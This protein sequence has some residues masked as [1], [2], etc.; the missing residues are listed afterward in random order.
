MHYT[1]PHS[2]LGV[3]G[4]HAPVL[5]I[6]P[7]SPFVVFYGEPSESQDAELKGKL[8]LNNPESISV[9]SVRV[10]LTATRKVSYALVPRQRHPTPRLL[11]PHQM[12]PHQHRQPAAHYAKDK[13][14]R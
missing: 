12:A 7:E 5:E 11:M 8:I 9:R 6:K 13:L 3:F 1:M 14:P 2:G 10:T 4:R